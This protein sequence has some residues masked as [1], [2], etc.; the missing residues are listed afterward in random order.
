[1]PHHLG[2][3]RTDA[4]TCVITGDPDRVPALA[5]SVGL[6][7]PV[8]RRRGYVCVEAQYQ[9][10]PVLVASSGIGGPTMAIAAEELWQVGVRRLIRVGTCGSMRK[11]VHAGDI[12]ISTGA[13]RDDGTSAQYL[14]LSIPANPDPVL[15]GGIL[16]AARRAS[17]AHHLGLTHCK[18]AYYAERPEGLP[19]AAEWAGRWAM[20]RSVG[21]LA[22]EMEAGALFA[23]AMVR[24]FRAAAL[25]VAVD[26]TLPA[27][28]LFATLGTAT[29]LALDG[30]LAT[31]RDEV[32]KAVR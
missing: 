19:L 25:L 26:G 32:I 5:E 7:G 30:A 2:D 24:G 6:T 16:A 21:V 22:T 9:G 11:D 29:R 14:P 17:V 31:A 28:D 10:E 12:V 18:D 27:T 13:V 8:W 20:L 3:L 15:L 4:R 23:V 1:M